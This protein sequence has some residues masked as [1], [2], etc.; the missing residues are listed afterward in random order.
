M[1]ARETLGYPPTHLWIE[2]TNACNLQCVHCPTGTGLKRHRGFIDFELA[3]RLIEQAAAFKPLVYFHL[4]G[5]SLLH[6][7]LAD[8]IR[9]AHSKGLPT[10]MFTNATILDRARGGA[11]IAAGLDWLG[12]S[13]DGLDKE[14]YESVRKGGR[15]DKVLGNILAFLALRKELGTAAPY[16]YMSTVDLLH[17]PTAEQARAARDLKERL[18]HAGLDHMEVATPHTWAGLSLGGP[19]DPKP[20]APPSPCPALWSGLAILWDGQASPCCLDIEGRLPVGDLTTQTLAEVWN[21]APLAGLRAAFATGRWE[22]LPSACQ[23]CHIPRQPTW[24]GIPTKAWTEL[25]EELLGVG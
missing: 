7:R 11:L 25:K 22:A 10:G 21:G 14:S 18:A 13:F 15:F 4:G 19:A 2:P 17:S 9:L 24:M 8:I 16:T 1:R 23:A 3:E 6:P 12:F 20:A 5:E